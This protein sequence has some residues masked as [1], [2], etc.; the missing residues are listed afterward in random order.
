MQKDDLM[1]P[2]LLCKVLLG[3]SLTVLV[4]LLV[5]VAATFLHMAGSH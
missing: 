5:L 4:A 1:K 3:G 2:D